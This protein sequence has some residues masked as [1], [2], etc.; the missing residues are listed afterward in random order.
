MSGNKISVLIDQSKDFV[1]KNKI[2]E[3][4]ANSLKCVWRPQVYP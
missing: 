2:N 1:N 4:N 3:I